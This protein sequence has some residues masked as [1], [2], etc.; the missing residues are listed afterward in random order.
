MLRKV[1]YWDDST[2]KKLILEGWE[3]VSTQFI[4]EKVESMPKRLEDFITGNGAMTG[5]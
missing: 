1:P 4:N 2:T 5:H 3:N